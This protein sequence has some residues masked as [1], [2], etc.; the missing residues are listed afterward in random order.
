MLP[1]GR[2]H[3]VPGFDAARGIFAI[4]VCVSHSWQVFVLPTAPALTAW[5]YVFGL[6]ARL[7]V[8]GFFCL[9]GYLIALSVA[10]NIDKYGYF[11]GDEYISSRAIRIL[12]PLLF[13]IVLAYALYR[14]AVFLGIDSLPPGVSGARATYFDDLYDQ[15]LSLATLMTDGNLT[16]TL[17]GPLW[18]LQYEI[19]LYIILGLVAYF[20]FSTRGRWFRI[21]AVGLL[22][23]YAHKAFYLYSLSGA[24]TLQF[25]WYSMFGLGVATFLLA[26]RTNRAVGWL[27]ASASLAGAA[28]LFLRHDSLTLVNDLDTSAALMWGQFFSALFI[29]AA[30]G[31]AADG[32]TGR[33]LAPLGRFSYTLYIVHFP[34]MLF[35]YF[36]LVNSGVRYSTSVGWQIAMLA[37]FASVFFAYFASR[38]VENTRAQREFFREWQRHR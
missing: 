18:S 35:S 23:L 16:G 1:E 3:N 4:I 36:L 24:T 15:W 8:I 32:N 25:L 30:I 31:L 28:I 29:C 5:N 20:L 22:L 10:R 9:S 6:S 34:L 14:L 37:S 11:R 19:Q 21:V 13:A 26:P 38:F 12:P 7:A 2:K 33:S 27:I 17:N